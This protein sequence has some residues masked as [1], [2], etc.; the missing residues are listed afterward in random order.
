M[1]GTL[2]NA[3]TVL[4]GS[5]IGLLIGNRLPARIQE[6]VITG[7]GLMTLYIGFSNGLKTGNAIIPLL[8]LVI[9]VIIGELLRL[10]MQ[11]ERLAGWLEARF[12]ARR[13]SNGAQGGEADAAG[14]R[15]ARFIQGF[16]TASLVFCVGPL[17]FLGSMQDGM[18]LDVG[19]QQLAIK[20]VLDG[21]SSMAFAASLGIGVL[22]SVLAVLGIQGGLA[23]IGS[24]AGVFMTTPM[25]DEMT[26]TGGLILIG[27]GLVLLDIKKPRIANFLPALILAPLIVAVATAVGIN[28]YPNI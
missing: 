1:G 26:A 17:T 14:D 18:G 28:I 2:L 9:G 7:L 8:S 3:L 21:F 5:T 23:L 15:R 13:G 6:S 27:L 25:L 4:I 11:L 10:D 22:F 20:S 19:F 12:S 24:V 16:V